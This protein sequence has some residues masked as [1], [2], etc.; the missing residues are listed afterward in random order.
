MTQ[1]L[2][3][4]CDLQQLNLLYM[5]RPSLWPHWPFLP[6]IRQKPGG[7]KECGLLYDAFGLSG[8]TGFSASVLKCNL[9]CLPPTE[10]RLL[11][12][13]REVYDTPEEVFAAGWRTD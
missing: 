3:S 11:A 13:P 1:A 5:S 7:E 6:L 8:R 4:D 12:L 2:A 9:F 10:E